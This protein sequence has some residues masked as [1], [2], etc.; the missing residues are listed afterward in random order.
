MSTWIKLAHSPSP[1]PL[2][3]FSKNKHA[4]YSSMVNIRALLV[5][6][7]SVQLSRA[8]T[9]AVR[10]LAVRRQF[11]PVPEKPEFPVLDYLSVQYRVLPRLAEAYALHFTGANMMRLY[12]TFLETKNVALI[13]EVGWGRVFCA[14]AKFSPHALCGRSTPR[15]P[16]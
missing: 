6:T 3:Q 15:A 16:A 1:A 4:A 12:R 14:H 2:P 8:T 9:I 13:A 5:S 11:A 10:Y 7:A